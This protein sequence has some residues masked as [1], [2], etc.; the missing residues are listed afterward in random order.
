MGG[1]GLEP[2]RKSERKDRGSDENWANEVWT[3]LITKC[4]QCRSVCYVCECR[5]T[6]E[7]VPSDQSPGGSP[8]TAQ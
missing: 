2:V 1:L 3:N 8:R 5:C 7:Y 4:R 6:I